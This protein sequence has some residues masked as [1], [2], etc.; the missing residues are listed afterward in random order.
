MVL[1]FQRSMLLLGGLAALLLAALH[2]IALPKLSGITVTTSWGKDYVVGMPS[3]SRSNERVQMQ[4]DYAHGQQT[5]YQLYTRGC[6]A[7]VLLNGVEI[8]IEPAQGR[9]SRCDFKDGMRM[10]LA[11]AIHPGA[12]HLDIYFTA[13]GALHMG[14]LIF[15]GHS[16]AG[17][18]GAALVATIG[19]MLVLTGRHITGLW[20]TGGIFVGALGLYLFQFVQTGFLHFAMDM[21]GHLQYIISIVDWG[22]LP[23]PYSGWQTYH[24]PLYY[25]LQAM[26][27]LATRALGSFDVVSVLRCFSMLCMFTLLLYAARLLRMAIS[28]NVAYL[29]A[30]ALLAFYPA[31]VMYAARID[32]NLLF[33][34]IYIAALFHF[35]LWMREK[36]NKH[37]A[38]AVALAGMGMATRSNTLVL[39]AMMGLIVLWLWWRHQR[40]PLPLRYVPLWA[41]ALLVALGFGANYGRTAYAQYTS[42]EERSILV[43]NVGSLSKIAR[44]DNKPQDFL[45]MD[46]HAYLKYPFWNPRKD[47]SGRQNF[48]TSVLKTSLFG[49]FLWRKPE[50]ALILGH[51]LLY[52]VIFCLLS[53]LFQI[54]ALKNL[55]IWRFFAFT[56]AFPLFALAL[57][58][59]IFAYAPSQDF[60]YIY[61]ALVSFVG[62]YGLNLQA[63]L[64]TKHY[65]LAGIGLA[66]GIAMTL[67]SAG[68]FISQQL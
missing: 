25:T 19:A 55:Q 45:S 31:S 49:E 50:I 8:P 40:F 38:I 3:F 57:N 22:N 5:L 68:F 36:R 1:S 11:P 44:I 61:P 35:F 17:Y 46:I 20:A 4:V 32:S 30:L 26:I 33:Y 29:A 59:N 52:L 41:A 60:R 48:W 27:V 66:L 63:Y 6:I 62:L 54:K 2:F 10:D 15:K 42:G 39:L 23:S 18:I 51:L 34:T 14:P 47:Y 13:P 53:T 43:G 67:A 24:P 9:T 16:L 58:R 21:P 37:L 12:N 7:R 28:H 56:L 65:L 64:T